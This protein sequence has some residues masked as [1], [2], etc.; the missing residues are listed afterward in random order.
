MKTTKS[1]VILNNN[2]NNNQMKKNKS[3]HS[4]N[5]QSKPFKTPHFNNTVLNYVQKRLE[6]LNKSKTPKQ[7]SITKHE[8]DQINKSNNNTTHCLN[9][10]FEP[11]KTMNKPVMTKR[12]TEISKPKIHLDEDRHKSI[13]ILNRY[14]VRSKS[15]EN[16]EVFV[17]KKE[18][19]KLKQEIGLYRSQ[20]SKLERKMNEHIRQEHLNLIKDQ[21]KYR[22]NNRKEMKK[23]NVDNKAIDDTINS[24][25]ISFS[26]D[27]KINALITKIKKKKCFL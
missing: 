1:L 4:V 17:L 10:V 14:T 7:T 18:N 12:A 11:N 16:S 23:N 20:L 19:K 6:E 13:D 5:F 24:L 9:A 15:R 27:E 3:F 21:Y 25:S 8:V 26:E 2:N 22:Y